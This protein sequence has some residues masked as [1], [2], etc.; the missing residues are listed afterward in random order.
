MIVS[1]LPTDSGGNET[2]AGASSTFNAI[3][4]S[5]GYMGGDL[6]TLDTRAAA[7]LLPLD[8]STSGTETHPIKP[9]ASSNY[10]FTL[11]SDLT[12][13]NASVLTHLESSALTGN[14][15]AN[16]PNGLFDPNALFGSDN[17]QHASSIGPDS[18]QSPLSPTS[19]DVAAV[20]EPSTLL[21]LVSAMAGLGVTRRKRKT[22]DGNLSFTVKKSRF[23][24]AFF[25][26]C[27]A[28]AICVPSRTLRGA[29]QQLAGFLFQLG[30]YF[31]HLRISRALGANRGIAHTTRSVVKQT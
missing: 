13:S 1:R 7:V 17:F 12:A 4:P 20:P 8:K 31:Q 21:L 22:T 23:G 29:M 28:F 25:F 27:K 16:W 11:Y 26:W 14:E 18:G 19:A 24:R 5:I 30:G 3:N 6:S 10:Y 15:T 2:V 9:V